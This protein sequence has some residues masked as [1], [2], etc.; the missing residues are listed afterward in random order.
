M[1]HSY[2]LIALWLLAVEDKYDGW[3]GEI[4]VMESRGNRKY[5]T[6]FE[7]TLHY[8]QLF[9]ENHKSNSTEK[10]NANGFDSAFHKYGLI[11]DDNGIKFLLD[12]EVILSV[13]VQDGFWKMGG[14]EGENKWALGEKMA[15]FDQE[16]SFSIKTAF[17]PNLIRSHIF[18]TVLFA[19]ELGCRQYKRLF[20]R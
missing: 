14:F 6:K 3:S 20:P 10:F 12:D 19:R 15:P 1:K 9:N 13:P 8:G 18:I 2:F 11:W 5:V 17:Q 7:S 16:V 4:D